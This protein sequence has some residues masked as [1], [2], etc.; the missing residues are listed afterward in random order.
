[1]SAPMT[2]LV[3][4]VPPV[5]RALVTGASGFIG[6]HAVAA[7]SDRGFEVHAVSSRPH[8]DGE[9]VAWHVVDLLEAGAP[10]ELLG[11][12]APTHLLHLAWY[13]EPGAFWTAPANVQWLEASLAL[14][15]AFAA[16]GGKRVVAAGSCA[17]YDWSTA[18]V[19]READ[20]PL[21]PQTLYGECKRS[22][23]AVA[24]QLYAAERMP[25]FAWGRIFFLYGSHEHAQ[26]LIPSV[27]LALLEGREAACTE[28]LQRR[29]FMDTRDAG[30]A[31]AALLDGEAEG[32]VNIASG[33]A[34]SIAEI[35][36]LV[37]EA[38]ARPELVRLGALPSRPGEPELLVAD[39]DR[40]RKEVGF[41]PSHDLREGLFETV[42]WWRE[43]L[44][45]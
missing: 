9:G 45:R 36:S 28:G 37:A 31:F 19:C 3:P 24:E 42:A 20:T 11:R 27:A 18:G 5:R 10:E 30:E 40:L 22:L 21:A 38:C 32:P 6:R 14:L 34:V 25:S 44:S 13:A 41:A 16:A 43:R 29:D 26:R 35:V 33:Q 15:R 2:D 23:C 8:E 12:I 1:M 39:V 7:L 17:E 4:G